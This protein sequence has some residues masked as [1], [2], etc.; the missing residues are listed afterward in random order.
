MLVGCS[1]SRVEPAI[2]TNC[3]PGDI[4]TVRN[5]A[6]IVPPYE[7]NSGHHGVSAAIQYAVCHLEVEHIIVLGHSDCGG[8]KTLMNSPEKI[9]RE[10]DFIAQWLSLA[11]PA[12][13]KVLNELP[14]KSP[15]MLRKAAEQA[16]ILMS[17]ENLNSFPFVKERSATGKLFLHGWYF[18]MK[19]GKLLNYDFDKKY[20]VTF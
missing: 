16:V 13:N 11:I 1:D 12:K 6:N 4:F 2:I 10:K 3:R 9:F 8:I 15:E 18:D 20:F 19:K 5:V 14:G 17:L 7:K